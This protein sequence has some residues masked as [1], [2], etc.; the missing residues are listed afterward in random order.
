MV[1]G[2]C[3]SSVRD[4]KYTL[5]AQEVDESLS[6]ADVGDAS[7]PDNCQTHVALAPFRFVAF[8]AKIGLAMIGMIVVGIMAFEQHWSPTPLS[9]TASRIVD[10][11]LQRPDG[12]QT[13]PPRFTSSTFLQCA[14]A[15]ALG[16]CVEIVGPHVHLCM[17]IA[18]LDYNSLTASPM[19]MS[20]LKLA[21]RSAVNIS[22]G[23]F[24]SF[25]NICIALGT[26]PDVV[27]DVKIPPDDTEGPTAVVA[28]NLTAEL[29]PR[30]CSSV[31]SALDKF[32]AF[33]PIITGVDV[34]CSLLDMQVATAESLATMML[35]KRLR[36][37]ANEIQ[38]STSN[39]C[40]IGQVIFI[41]S[42]TSAEEFNSITRCGTSSITLK[43]AVKQEH[44]V[45]TIIET[46]ADRVVAT[47]ASRSSSTFITTPRTTTVS[48][49]NVREL[50]SAEKT[51]AMIVLASAKTLVKGDSS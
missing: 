11:F 36:K 48:S 16:N 19:L 8:R 43:Q 31:V 17:K 32:A 4:F 39:G 42:H 9:G 50:S 41:A 40:N 15:T 38:V 44:G 2:A 24:A 14:T 29:R 51:A 22:S 46:Y 28:H 12:L 10:L 3:E 7:E 26:G 5:V 34:V 45:G 6:D 21:V 18:F 27:V 20:E 47:T 25:K 37:G 13:T 23:H 1:H 30:V 33:G 49:R 35:T